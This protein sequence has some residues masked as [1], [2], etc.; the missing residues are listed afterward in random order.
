MVSRQSCDRTGLSRAFSN[1]K[2]NGMGTSPNIS[3]IEPIIGSKVLINVDVVEMENMSSQFLAVKDAASSSSS[4]SVANQ[5]SSGL[6][7]LA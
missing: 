6:C 3:I 7:L 2:N 1:R 4:S 5:W